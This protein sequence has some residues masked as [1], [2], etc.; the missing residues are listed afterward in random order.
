[1]VAEKEKEFGEFLN[2]DFLTDALHKNIKEFNR[3]RARIFAALFYSFLIHLFDIATL[4][5]LFYAFNFK[6]NFSVATIG[7]VFGVVLGFIS[8]VPA[9]IGI[10]EAGRGLILN[11]FGAPL[12]IAMLV[13]VVFRALV[14]WINIPLGALAYKNLS[15]SLEE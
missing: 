9:G 14:F 13:P 6:V 11:L 3:T 10:E 8:F 5:F 12:G 4:Y 15:K 7:F 1:M 2:A